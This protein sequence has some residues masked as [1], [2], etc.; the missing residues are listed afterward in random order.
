M[1]FFGAYPRIDPG[2]DYYLSLGD[3]YKIL[4]PRKVA[5]KLYIFLNNFKIQRREVSNDYC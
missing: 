3:D 2:E 4:A 5:A 1:V